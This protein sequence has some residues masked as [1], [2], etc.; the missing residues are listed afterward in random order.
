MRSAEWTFPPDILGPFDAYVVRCIAGEFEASFLDRVTNTAGVDIRL[1][2]ATLVLKHFHLKV[3]DIYAM[4][5]AERRQLANDIL[6]V[7]TEERNTMP[8]DLV[9][10]R[11]V[12]G[13]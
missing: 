8:G 5:P 12:R 13:D 10:L 7:E 1:R 11:T 6:V 3:E 2:M 9:Q 4:G